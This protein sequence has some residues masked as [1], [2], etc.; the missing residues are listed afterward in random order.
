[1]TL[2]WVGYAIVIV[3]EMIGVFVQRSGASD[4]KRDRKS[5]VLLYAG[6][7]VSLTLAF[8]LAN[9][10]QAAQIVP[11]RHI[12]TLAGVALMLGGT[13][14]RWY[15]I[16]VLGRFFTR[17]VAIRPDHRIVRAGPYRFLRHPSY[18]G[19][20]IAVTGIGG[21]LNNWASLCAL[22][23][24]NFIVWRHRMNVEEAALTAVFGDAYLAYQK[25]TSR[26]VPGVY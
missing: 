9:T 1:M 5:V 19:W 6:I 15:S 10:W 16:A 17:D 4:Q 8:Y 13:A 25:E 20:L 26:L 2:F 23:V 7:T 14:F 12:M 11:Q 22:L 3:P 18:T 21:A 24:I